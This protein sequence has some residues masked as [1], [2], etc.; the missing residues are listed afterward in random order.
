MAVAD[1]YNATEDTLLTVPQATGLLVNDS[2]GDNDPITPIIVTQPAHGVLTLT[3]TPLDGSFSFQPAANYNGPDSFTYKVNDGT[4]DSNTV[5][6]TLTIA[7]V[8]DAPVAV[9]DVAR[10]L[11]DGVLTTVA[12]PTITTLIVPDNSPARGDIWKYLDNGSNQGSA[13]ARSEF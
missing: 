1:A 11:E 5:T 4:A 7:P 10:M 13:C 3:G 9:G 2:D 8:N 6:V 12:A